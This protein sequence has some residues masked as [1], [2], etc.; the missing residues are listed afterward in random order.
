MSA[1]IDVLK[2]APE[3][4]TP[5]HDITKGV[6]ASGLEASL[7]EL[8]RMRAS[9]INGCG[10]CIALHHREG[11]Q[12]GESDD[13]LFGLSAW[14]EASWYTPRERA[15]V[16]WTETLTLIAQRHPDD[17][18]MARMK[19]RFSE[20]EIVYLTMAINLINTYNRLSIATHTPPENAEKLFAMMHQI[21]APA[22]A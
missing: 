10:F 3:A 16:E 12:L 5:L 9:Q 19:E 13:R 22:T 7:L 11:R 18:L 20:R 6:A 4:M 15:A 8:V 21:A 14:R 1:T 17:D 2:V